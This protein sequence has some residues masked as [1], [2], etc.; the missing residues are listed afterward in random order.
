MLFHRSCIV[1]GSRKLSTGDIY[2]PHGTMERWNG[3]YSSICPDPLSRPGGRGF[4]LFTRERECYSWGM[5]RSIGWGWNASREAAS[6][7]SAAVPSPTCAQTRCRRY[8]H[9]SLSTSI[10]CY[11]IECCL[12]G[13]ESVSRQAMFCDISTAAPTYSIIKS[14]G[15]TGPPDNKGD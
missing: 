13:Y 1:R 5:E 12:Y 9:T 15:A 7:G 2:K 3:R 4:R 8:T 14:L 11:V 10:P 6:D